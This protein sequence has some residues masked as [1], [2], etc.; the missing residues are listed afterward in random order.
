[1]T[2][3]DITPPDMNFG[4]A[5]SFNVGVAPSIPAVRDVPVPEAPELVL[6]SVPTYLTL[7]TPSFEGI[8]LHQSYLDKLDNI[9]TLELVA[10]TPYS[11]A[12]GP[13]YASALLSTLKARLVERLTGGSGLTPAV[14]QAIWDRA[15]SRETVLAQANQDEVMRSSEAFG[16]HLPTGVLAAQL[17]EAQ[18]GYYGKLS[19]LSRDVAIKQAELEQENM[20]QTIAQGMEMEGRL[21]DYSVKLEQLAFD[22]AKEAASNAIL[23]YNAQ[24]D[25]FKALLAGYQTYATAYDTVIKGELAKVEVFRA[26][27]SAEQTKADV[28]RSLVEQY[29]A[30]VEAAMSYVTIYQARISAANALVQLEQ[31]KIGAYG[32]RIRAYTASVN[33]ETAKLEVFKAQVSA[34]GLKTE[35]YK[36][37]TQGYVAQAGAQAEKARAEVSRFAALHQAKASEW[38]GYSATVAAEGERVKAIG[39]SNGAQVESYKAQ[40]AATIATAE[41]NNS[42]WKASLAQYG[43][44]QSLGLQAGKINSES[45]IATNN[46]RLDAAKVGAQVYAQLTSSAYGMIHASAG[47]SGSTGV[48]YSY[49]G[50]VV[51]EVAPMT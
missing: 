30:T 20:K 45:L 47:V 13:E 29:K 46:A 22:A 33:A 3:F 7:S 19:S 51:G 44:A 37:Q 17:R 28:N 9:P 36:A 35:M 8:D 11:Y 50:K 2:E 18:Q 21:I 23:A 40:S 48:S 12:L 27:L 15:R 14:E 38:Q 4:V 42:V 39:M 32:E 10:P 6:P 5:P 34:E 41:L 16:F 24:V 25:N 49:S 43:A 31:T 1:M 26:L